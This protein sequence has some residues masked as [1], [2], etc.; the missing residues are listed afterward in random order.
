[1]EIKHH[2]D[3]SSSSSSEHCGKTFFSHV[4]TLYL[5]D[6]YGIAVPG[7]EFRVKLSI[8]KD[9]IAPGV[10]HVTIQIENPI[11]FV[12]GP[13][14]NNLYELNN[15]V[16]EIIDGAPGL[17]LPP[18]Q[19]G[20]YLYTKD[21]FLPC[22]IR[23]NSVMTRTYF[24]P[25]N[26]G[27]NIPFN[28]V[29]SATPPPD[30]SGVLV[31]PPGP[32][33]LIRVTNSGG[34]VIEGIG[35]LGNIIPPGTQQLLPTTFSYIRRLNIRLGKN[36][37]ISTGAINIAQYD[38]PSPPTTG[39]R[40]NV[41]DHHVNDAWA[42]RVWF[43]W[44]DNSNIP[45]PPA[46]PGVM[47]L[48]YAFGE[49]KH[50]KLHMNP[51]QFL[52]TPNTLYVWDTAV[53]INRTNPNNIVISYGLIDNNSPGDGLPFST[54]C[55]AVSFDGGQ[56]WASN[57]AT[58]VQPTGMFDGIPTGFGDLPGVRADKFG[59]F[60]Y[61][62]SNLADDFGDIINV[63]AIMA[64]SDGGRT[65]TQVYTFPYDYTN[66]IDLYGYPSLCF[67]GDGQ[68]NYGVQMLA[69]FF[70][71]PD[72]INGY[73]VR[74][75]IPITGLGQWNVGAVQEA[76][77]P[78]L[79]NNIFT[80]S[81]T[82]SEDGKV[83]TYGS[84]SG[85]DPAGYVFPGGFTNNRLVY[86]SPGPIDQNYA[87]PWGVVRYNSLSDSIYYPVWQAN[88]L[89]GFF[90]SVQN[91]IYD[92]KRKALYVILNATYPE[93]SNNSKIYLVISR[94]NGSTWSNPIF[95]NSDDK[96]NRGFMSMALDATTGNLV[97]GWYDARNYKDGLSFNYWGAVFPSKYLDELVEEIPLSNP[98]YAIPNGGY[99]VVPIDD[100]TKSAKDTPKAATP[101]PKGAK[102]SVKRRIPARLQARIARKLNKK[103]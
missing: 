68:G 23:P 69:D 89:F 38:N 39:S 31:T 62:Y 59:N 56:T 57:G 26:N 58:N 103:P 42:N 65:W 80:A 66:P 101:A 46:N 24:G 30:V 47:N 77:L 87:G 71:G 86:K 19:N 73:P 93:L 29:I 40:D 53:A 100:G 10:T 98:V 43:A 52:P 18:P 82:A 70:L 54:V 3:D 2:S 79:L 41:R 34:L 81:I 97:L 78:W 27:Q 85:L 63:P 94:D 76:P 55:A 83:W 22:D 17:F 13:Y 64:S 49:V 67:G 50:E 11:N 9:V 6:A 95:I 36:T 1:M 45:N 44:A 28:Y 51:A 35:T 90:Q 75:F 88:P 21:G 84:A 48:A 61:M 12:T 33:Y 32:G 8:I 92:E 4:I 74:A 7:V 14:A 25:S 99:D 60:W 20:G 37:Q 5:A 102:N 16:S 91:N 72:L 96:N 15:P